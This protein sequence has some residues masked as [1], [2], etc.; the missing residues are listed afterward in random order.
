MLVTDLVVSVP[1]EAPEIVAEVSIPALRK[2]GG[3]NEVRLSPCDHDATPY[4]WH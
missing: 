1:D 4:Q 3:G 2:Q